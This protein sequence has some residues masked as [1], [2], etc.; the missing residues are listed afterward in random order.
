VAFAA[1]ACGAA[2]GAI[3]IVAV[4]VNYHEGENAPTV[5]V[6]DRL[7]AAPGYNSGRDS[8]PP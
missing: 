2:L 1:F 6:V 8:G 7:V 5:G 3:A 4:Y